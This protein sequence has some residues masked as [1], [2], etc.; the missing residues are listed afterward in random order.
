MQLH[1]LAELRWRH[2]ERE[3]VVVGLREQR[4]PPGPMENTKSVDHIGGGETCLFEKRPRDG[5]TQAKLGVLLER[6]AK[7]VEGRPIRPFRDP[8]EDGEVPV[9]VEVRAPRPEV[10]EPEPAETPGL[11]QVKIQDDLQGDSPFAPMASR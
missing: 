3:G 9:H 1:L 6:S 5:E 7:S 8:P 4:D 2:E 10:E 11:M